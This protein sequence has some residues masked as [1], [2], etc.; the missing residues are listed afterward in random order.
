MSQPMAAQSAQRLADAGK[1]ED[2]SLHFA[3]TRGDRF[4]LLPCSRLVTDNAPE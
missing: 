1:R 3:F 2:R 4:N